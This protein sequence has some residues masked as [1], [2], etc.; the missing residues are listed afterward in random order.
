MVRHGWRTEVNVLEPTT[1]RR[2]RIWASST[3]HFF[4][5]QPPAPPSRTPTTVTSLPPLSP[6]H[7]HLLATI[8]LSSLSLAASPHIHCRQARQ[9][10]WHGNTTSP[11]K[12]ALDASM[13]HNNIED[14]GA[15]LP[16]VMW[17]PHDKWQWCSVCCCCLYFYTTVSPS[18]PLHPNWHCEQ[19]LHHT[20]TTTSHHGYTTPQWPPQWY[21]KA[22][23]PWDTTAM[24]RAQCSSNNHDDAWWRWQ[25]CTMTTVHND[26]N[27]NAQWM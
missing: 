2:G 15:T 10:E 8:T 25:G 9:Q 7:H 23:P 27:N 19:W 12:W 26:D 18:S 17:Q 3:H 20:T 1:T 4:V 21:H 6:H 16:A 5:P 14:S 24:A 11:T 22:T 13:L